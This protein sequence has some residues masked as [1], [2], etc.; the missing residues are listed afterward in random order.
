MTRTDA[1]D[2]IQCLQEAFGDT[3]P[4]LSA[5]LEAANCTI[6]SSF[7]DAV[8]GR[9]WR[10][11]RPLDSYIPDASDLVLL[12]AK[13]YCYYLPAYLY[14]LV[15]G[16]SDNVYLNGVLDSLWYEGLYFD[17]PFQ[18]HLWDERMLLL[19][20]AQKRCIGHFLVQILRRTDDSVLGEGSNRR[21]IELMLKKY[22]NARF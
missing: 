13:A 22:W 19:T 7:P 2:L 14:A 4:P 6:E 3:E 20:E 1:E 10:D 5:E 8:R 9:S 21:R 17:S 18:R 11:L 12:S 15:G 16:E